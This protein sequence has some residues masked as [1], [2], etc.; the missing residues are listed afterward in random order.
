MWKKEK[1]SLCNSL[2]LLITQT[3]LPPPTPPP[4][5]QKKNLWQTPLRTLHI[6]TS[7]FPWCKAEKKEARKW[8]IQ[9][10]GAPGFFLTWFHRLFAG[11]WWFNSCCY[12]HLLPALSR[13]QLRL[14]QPGTLYMLQLFAFFF[15]FSLSHFLP[16]PFHFEHAKRG[17]R[18]KR[19]D[20]PPLKEHITRQR[21]RY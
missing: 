16:P 5:I 21:Q 11:L 14:T 20:K 12:K 17:K 15:F 6:I 19:S 13:S 9:K 3:P 10:Y 2:A 7:V 8:E 4:F 18:A 1:K